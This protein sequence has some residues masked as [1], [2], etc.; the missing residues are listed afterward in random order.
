MPTIERAI[1]GYN[2]DRFTFDIT[3]WMSLPEPPRKEE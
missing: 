3:H 2:V 1:D